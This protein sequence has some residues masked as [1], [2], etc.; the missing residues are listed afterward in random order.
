MYFFTQSGIW[1]NLCKSALPGTIEKLRQR[2]N[3]I[4]FKT[5]EILPFSRKKHFQ[6]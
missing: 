1:M 4:R 3:G 5:V 2:Y 6:Q